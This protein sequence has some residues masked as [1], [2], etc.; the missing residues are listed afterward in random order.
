M[1][2]SQS[3]APGSAGGLLLG[4]LRDIAA[5]QAQLK[6]EIEN[7]LWAN[8]LAGMGYSEAD[9]ASKAQAVFSHLFAMAEA[10]PRALH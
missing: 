5:K 1:S 6:L 2:G 4:H 10:E 7:H 8:D 9:I 3:N